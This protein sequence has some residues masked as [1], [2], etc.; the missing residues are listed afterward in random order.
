MFQ[1][2]YIAVAGA[3]LLAGSL[4][5]DFTLEQSSKITGGMMAGMMKVAGAFSKQAR[6][7]IQM[8]LSVKGDRMSTTT[9]RSMSIIDL[10]AETMTEVDLDKKTYAVI[11]F[12]DFSRALQKMSEKAG[13]QGDA[14]LNVKADVKQTGETRNI[15][16]F[17][18]KQTLLTI[19]IEG[20]DQKSGDKGTMTVVTDM[21]LAPNMLGYEEVRAFYAKM[22]E[23]LAWSPGMGGFGSMMTAQPGVAKGMAQLA[24]EASK[25]EG[26]PVLQVVRMGGM[27]GAAGQPGTN[28]GQQ[29]SEPAPSAGDA[30]ESAAAS[31]ATSRIGR[32][33]GIA[34]GGLGG[35]GRSKKKQPEQQAQTPPPAAS[36][37]ATPPGT[38]MELT[39]EMTAF[40]SAPVDEAKLTVPA[41]F[42][43]V[44]HQMQKALK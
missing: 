44:E 1:K 40:S 21:W 20:Q 13:G 33:G 19:E 16:G 34:A 22:A 7:P 23:K 9:A 11:T 4:R 42:K 31:A 14:S 43:Q 29:T 5:A 32:F 6:E 18:A 3:V 26:V 17:Q 10:N 25:L 37:N 38:L 27:Q 36:K 8:T 15:N 39:T 35:F 28:E 12:A 2:K 24:K 30:A 41:G